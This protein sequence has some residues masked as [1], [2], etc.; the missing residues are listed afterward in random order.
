MLNRSL[1]KEGHPGYKC[2]RDFTNEEL[3][4]FLNAN[5]STDFMYL[6]GITSEILRRMN[7]K[8]PLFPKEDP[9]HW[10]YPLIP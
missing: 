8:R 10:D 7:E 6:T 4:V 9:F 5:E 1:P 2:L 3:I